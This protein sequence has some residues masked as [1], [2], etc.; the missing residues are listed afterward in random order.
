MSFINRTYLSSLAIYLALL[1]TSA[2]VSAETTPQQ[3]YSRSVHNYAV[4]N[5]NVV[6]Q[7]G[8]RT[9]LSAI[10][11]H[12]GPV[13]MNFIF[14]SCNA[15]CPIMTA[16]LAKVH[17]TI[18]PSSPNLRFVS[19]SIDPENDTPAKLIEYANRFKAGPNWQF[20]TGDIAEL[21]LVQ[22]AFDAYRGDK[23]NHFSLTFMRA[24]STSSWL[25]IEGIANANEL[26]GEYNLLIA[27]PL[28][29]D[30]ST[31]GAELNMTK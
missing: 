28:V 22:R 30:T 16:I 11:D 18:G 14:T 10:L 20:L 21:Q 7:Y 15:I 3:S 19:I 4:P 31:S 6:T 13:M 24:S 12:G 17:A 23:M 8:Q 27:N 25:R 26:I 9:K 5:V 1:M 29:L 2:P